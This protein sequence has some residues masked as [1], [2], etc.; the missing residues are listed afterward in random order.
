MQNTYL[1]KDLTGMYQELLKLNC[2]K[3]S[4]LFFLKWAKDL[5]TLY[6]RRYTDGKKYMKNCSTSLVIGEMQI[7]ITMRNQYTPT[8]GANISK[9]NHTKCWQGCGGPGTLYTAG[10]NV[11]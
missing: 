10:G 7:D 11:K 4:D 5:N 1:T 2:K 3:K 9:M 8:R 6:Q